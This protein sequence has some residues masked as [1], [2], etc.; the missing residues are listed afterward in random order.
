MPQND[1]Q[2]SFIGQQF[3]TISQQFSFPLLSLLS[4]NNYQQLTNNL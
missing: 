2:N 1:P 4:V 3:S